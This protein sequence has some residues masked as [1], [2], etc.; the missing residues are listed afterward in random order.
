[1]AEKASPSMVFV[2][3]RDGSTARGRLNPEDPSWRIGVCARSIEWLLPDCH[4]GSQRSASR[5]LAEIVPTIAIAT[6]TPQI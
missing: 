3:D 5:R 1:L 4:L 6:I 2:V